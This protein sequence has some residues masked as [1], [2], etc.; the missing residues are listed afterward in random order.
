MLQLL[1]ALLFTMLFTR[2]PKTQPGRH[3]HYRCHRGHLSCEAHAKLMLIVLIGLLVPLRELLPSH[4]DLLHQ[5]SGGDGRSSTRNRRIIVF[6][7]GRSN[8]RTWC[9]FNLEWKSAFNCS[10]RHKT[11]ST[12][13]LAPF[14]FRC[15]CS[16]D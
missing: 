6:I 12:H 15:L 10:G 13:H 11:V 8:F 1:F 14:P 2:H 9:A 16:Y 5:T 4:L 7:A 3:C